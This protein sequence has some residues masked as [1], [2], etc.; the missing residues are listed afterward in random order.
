M[1]QR[2]EEEGGREGGQARLSWASCPSLNFV[3][4]ASS[5]LSSSESHPR[6]LLSPIRRPVL[7][8]TPKRVA[9]AAVPTPA[10]GQ[11]CVVPLLAHSTLTRLAP[12][13]RVL[14][15]RS[16][17]QREASRGAAEHPAGS[18]AASQGAG[19][20]SLRKKAAPPCLPPP[21]WLSPWRDTRASDLLNPSFLAPVSSAAPTDQTRKSLPFVELRRLSAAWGE[22]QNSP[23]QQLAWHQVYQELMS[24][25][26]PCRKVSLTLAASPSSMLTVS[27]VSRALICPQSLH[28]S[29][30]N[31]RPVPPPQT[32]LPTSLHGATCWNESDSCLR[33][34]VP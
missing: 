2:S 33:A 26:P 1:G 3:A 8:S 32:P 9:L 28:H 23:S 30:K 29:P 13:P 31:T 10:C 19:L 15:Q 17:G 14:P 4:D 12:C 21:K 25:M 27:S 11:T 18:S 6:P 20:P 5:G 16:V 24:P 34:T 7:C 22:S